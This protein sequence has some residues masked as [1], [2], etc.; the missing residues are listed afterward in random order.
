MILRYGV[1]TKHTRTFTAKI[2]VKDKEEAERKVKSLKQKNLKEGYTKYFN[3]I[4]YTDDGDYVG[5][6]SIEN[7]SVG[8]Y[9]C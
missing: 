1:E 4:L 9:G 5:H 3:P 8:Y 2:L 7:D 6:F